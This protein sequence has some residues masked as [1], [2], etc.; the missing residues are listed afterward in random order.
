M[1]EDMSMLQSKEVATAASSSSTRGQS[2][3]DDTSTVIVKRLISGCDT[4]TLTTI[5]CTP[6]QLLPKVSYPDDS[7]PKHNA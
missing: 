6:V 1:E 5:V 4:T 3:V 7:F 2:I